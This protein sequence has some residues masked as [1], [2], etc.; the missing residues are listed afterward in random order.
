MEAHARLTQ[1]QVESRKADICLTI[2]I[3]F[4]TAICI[5][6]RILDVIANA[7]F[8]LTYLEDSLFSSTELL[9]I[10][11]FVNIKNVFLYMVQ[12]FGF[13]NAETK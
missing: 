9:F 4:L 10:Q 13:E 2:L 7:F 1:K 12:A 8:R 6:T 5:L 3:I 11:L